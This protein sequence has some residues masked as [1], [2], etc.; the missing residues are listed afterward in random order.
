MLRAAALASRA[1][2]A[3]VNSS[4]QSSCVQQHAA[5]IVRVPLARAFATNSTDIF[6]TNKDTPDNNWSVEF[7]FTPVS[8]QNIAF[9]RVCSLHY[10]V[11][12]DLDGLEDCCCIW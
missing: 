6:N 11:V 4:S 12:V 3:A 7:D 8:L 10:F 5:S 1:V 2:L 9:R